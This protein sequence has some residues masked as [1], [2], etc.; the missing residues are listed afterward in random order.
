VQE[1]SQRPRF[2]KFPTETAGYQQ[3]MRRSNNHQQ[4]R[5]KCRVAFKWQKW[6]V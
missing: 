3:V 6:I 2:T 5:L 4:M 1:L